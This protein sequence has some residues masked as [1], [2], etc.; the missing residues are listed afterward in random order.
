MTESPLELAHE[1]LAL[2]YSIALPYQTVDIGIGIMVTLM[3]FL[4]GPAEKPS[5]SSQY[6]T[7]ILTFC[8]ELS[9]CLIPRETAP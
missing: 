3:R 2:E 1:N 4:F 7:T 5:I 9:A 6:L 8:L